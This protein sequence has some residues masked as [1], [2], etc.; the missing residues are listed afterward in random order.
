MNFLRCS[1]Y[2][3]SIPL[4]MSNSNLPVIFNI[5]ENKNMINDYLQVYRFELHSIN[6]HYKIFSNLLF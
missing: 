1:L 4:A 2:D 5:F 6:K 3:L